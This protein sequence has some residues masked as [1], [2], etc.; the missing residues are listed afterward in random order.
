[1]SDPTLYVTDAPTALDR[2]AVLRPLM[3]H[4]ER[5]TGRSDFKPLAILLRNAEGQPMDGGLTGRSFYGWLFIE[6]LSV[7]EA[8]RGQ[9]LG[10]RLMQQAEAVALERG[11]LGI[12]LDTFSF[13]A[14]G[15]YE[16]LGYA[17]FGSIEDYPPGHQ[18]FFLQKRL[19]R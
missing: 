16:K 8:S 2:E 11:C 3:A 1:M 7:P 18:R 4:N 17:V 10:T 9:K 12:W 15:F 14:R 13:Q 19:H 5:Q 6:L